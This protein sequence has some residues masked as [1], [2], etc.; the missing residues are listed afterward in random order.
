MAQAGGQGYFLFSKKAGE[1]ESGD[2]LTEKSKRLRRKFRTFRPQQFA[3][4]H[5]GGRFP[6]ALPLQ[7]Q[8]IREGACVDGR[9]SFF[10]I[11]AFLLREGGGVSPST[12]ECRLM[13]PLALR[14]DVLLFVGV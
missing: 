14:R 11:A 1:K 10:Q 5:A 6:G 2:V 12:L 7:R 4:C 13:Q 9:S 3:D 8:H